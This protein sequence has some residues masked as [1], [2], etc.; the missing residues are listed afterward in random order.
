MA[1][2]IVQILGLVTNN[3]IKQV[4]YL[5]NNQMEN[6]YLVKVVFIILNLIRHLKA[7]T[8]SARLL[9]LAKELLYLTQLK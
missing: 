1:R 8:S 9:I 4:V 6:L 2:K 3:Q 5:E 7:I